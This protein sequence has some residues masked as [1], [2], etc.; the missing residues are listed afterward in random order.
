MSSDERT[1]VVAMDLIYI[2]LTVGFFAASAG[3]IRF[4]AALL[5]KRG[6]S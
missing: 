6:R 2:A 1:I 3:L 4:C 5:D